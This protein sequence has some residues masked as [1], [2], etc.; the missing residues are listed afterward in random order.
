MSI[1]FREEFKT[2]SGT[3]PPPRTSISLDQQS[4]LQVNESSQAAKETAPIKTRYS[5]GIFAGSFCVRC[6]CNLRNC[7]TGG[8]NISG[9][10]NIGEKWG[11]CVRVGG[12][13]A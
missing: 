5:N 8:L 9:K 2:H 13:D 11:V 3:F 7:H 1:G 6:T 12:G 4:V 10:G